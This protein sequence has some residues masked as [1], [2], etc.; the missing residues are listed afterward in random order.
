M[1]VVDYY[2]WNPSQIKKLYC[3]DYDFQGLMFWY[4]EIIR[5]NKEYKKNTN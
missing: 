3:D 2:K 1:S 4:N 5:I